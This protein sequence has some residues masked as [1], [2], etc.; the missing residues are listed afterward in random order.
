MI[1]EINNCAEC[2]FANNDNEYGINYCNL[3]LKIGMDIKLD[4]FEVLPKNTR[5]KDCP[6]DGK[7][8]INLIHAKY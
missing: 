1:L 2:P 4:N 6:I 5:H 8:E 7:I 3:A